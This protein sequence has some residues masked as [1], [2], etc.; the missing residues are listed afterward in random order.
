[1]VVVATPAPADLDPG[2][3]I[4]AADTV[5]LLARTGEP[6]AELALAAELV[7]GTPLLGVLLVE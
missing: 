7:R 3:V 4:A 5:I 6:V 2:L 1:V